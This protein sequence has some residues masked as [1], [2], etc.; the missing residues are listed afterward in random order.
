MAAFLLGDAT[1]WTTLVSV[2]QLSAPYL[3]LDASEVY[4]PPV[5]DL[6]LSS[7]LSKGAD[8]I[9]LAN[10]PL[11]ISTVYLSYVGTSGLTAEHI[12]IESYDGTTI[13][14]STPTQN[15]YLP[16]SRIQV[17]STYN[18]KQK[19]LLPGD[20]IFIPVQTGTNSFNVT[21]QQQ[22][23]DAFGSDINATFSFSGGDIAVVSGLNTLIQ[24]MTIALQTEIGSLP[25]HPEFGSR[26]N[27][28][29]G[30]PSQS[31][32]WATVVNTCLSRL[33]EVSHVTNIQVNVQGLT[34]YIS[35]WVYVHTSDTAIQMLNE[36]FTLT[37]TAA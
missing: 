10:Q 2:N 3:T 20:Y 4:G 28:T 18:L 17:F 34:A 36:P 22:L 14:L 13:T 26:L 24:R 23:V 8:Q 32:K 15:A 1:L 29:I 12:D 25:L 7:S 27:Q 35:A 37:Q 6:S 5:A 30:T 31:I 21:D 11:N 16:G 9:T 19:V 33:P